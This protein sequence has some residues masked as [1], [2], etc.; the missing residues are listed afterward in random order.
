MKLLRT[1]FIFLLLT[2]SL[3]TQAELLWLQNEHL[4]FLGPSSINLM[5][6][7]DTKLW[8]G[9]F[10]YFATEEHPDT[11]LPGRIYCE[12]GDL[13]VKV[14]DNDSLFKRSEEHTSEL[15]SH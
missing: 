3:N 1:S 9:T 5:R 4:V 14:Y 10:G 2:L 15:Q 11:R 7:K 8:D 6:S 12:N 13:K